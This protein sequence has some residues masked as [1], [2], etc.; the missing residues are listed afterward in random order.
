M[1]DIFAT[2]DDSTPLTVDERRGLKPSYISTRAELNSEEQRN[3]TK[4]QLWAEE[5]SRDILSI[6]AIKNL[7]ARMF[8]DVWEWAGQFSQVQDRA[9]GVQPYMIEQELRLLIDDVKFW[10]ENNTYSKTEIAVRFHHK[11]VWIHA[12][13]NGNGRH[14]RLATDILLRK[15]GEPPFTWDCNPKISTSNSALSFRRHNRVPDEGQGN[16]KPVTRRTGIGYPYASCFS[17]PRFSRPKTEPMR[18]SW[19]F[20][21]R[22]VISRR[23]PPG[24]LTRVAGSWDF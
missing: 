5:R 3:I 13:P 1:S 6:D 11:L 12:F 15:G 10:L 14:A 18:F 9:L 24:F 8:S 20:S 17:S 19:P 4:A 2:E 7:H 16:Q 23:Y 21:A 22:A